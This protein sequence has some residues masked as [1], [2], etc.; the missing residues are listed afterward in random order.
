MP[1]LTNF[2][3]SDEMPLYQESAKFRNIIVLN[4]IYVIS[5]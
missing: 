2:N 1:N 4:N 5:P 3:F